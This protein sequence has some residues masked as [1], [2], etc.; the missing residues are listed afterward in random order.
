MPEYRAYILDHN[1]HIKGC[2]PLI[3]T[4]DDAAIVA[5]KRLVDRH[6]VELWHGAR[7]VTK[8]SPQP[9]R[10]MNAGREGTSDDAET[11]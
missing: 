5:A 4:D 7:M 9:D 11:E 6:D 2:E 1:R 3:S 10:R 8:L